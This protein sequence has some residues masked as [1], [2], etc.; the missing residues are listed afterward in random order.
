LISSKNIEILS[1]KIRILNKR[2]IS[3]EE[4]KEL[5]KINGGGKVAQRQGAQFVVGRGPFPTSARGQATLLARLNTSVIFY[6]I[7]R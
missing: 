5:L 4:W 1:K 3:S 6:N 2:Y 7:S